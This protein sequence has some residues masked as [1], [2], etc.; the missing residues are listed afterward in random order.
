MIGL[1][2][3][4][5][6]SPVNEEGVVRRFVIPSILVVLCSC[7]LGATL[8][9]EQV[10]QAAQAVL[11]VKVTN[12]AAEPVPVT[13][14]VS[15]NG[16]VHVSDAAVQPYQETIHFNQSATTCTQF[17]CE[18]DFPAVPAGK[19]LVV[20]YVSAQYGL[21]PNGTLASI[22]LGINSSFSKPSILLPAQRS[23]FDTYLASGAVTF[24]VDA[25]DKPTLGLEGQFVQPASL[26]ASASI[27]G[28]LIPTT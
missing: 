15:V 28:Y 18:V 12:T 11:P 9:R 14:T 7:V 22:E 13:G 25:G 10:A 1:E 27:V 26:T 19:R 4:L 5:F 3:R 6:G 16:A 2:G 21:S 23:G 8:F 20:T 17:V 24:Y